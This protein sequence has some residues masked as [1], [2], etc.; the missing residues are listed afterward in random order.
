MHGGEEKRRGWRLC[1]KGSLCEVLD[2]TINDKGLI[3]KA[4]QHTM[5]A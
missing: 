5:F 3:H 4:L 2:G 1:T